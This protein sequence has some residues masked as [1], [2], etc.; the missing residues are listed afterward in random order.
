VGSPSGRVGSTCFSCALRWVGSGGSSSS[1]NKQVVERASG[2][3]NA[4][5]NRRQT[6]EDRQRPEFRTT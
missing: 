2:H 3:A 1:S 5:T 4:A 6:S